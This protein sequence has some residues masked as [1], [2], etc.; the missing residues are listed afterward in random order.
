MCSLIIGSV[1]FVLCFLQFQFA[2]GNDGCTELTPGTVSVNQSDSTM[3]D[4]RFDSDQRGYSYTWEFIN[5]SVSSNS[6]L[7]LTN[8]RAQDGGT[9]ICSVTVMATDID[10]RNVTVIGKFGVH[11]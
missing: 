4:C 3:I 5:T 1:V 8:V 2:E 9:Y 11:I 10:C 6:T 7:A